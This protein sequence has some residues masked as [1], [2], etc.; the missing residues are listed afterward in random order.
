MTESSSKVSNKKFSFIE[1]IRQSG[2]RSRSGLES[3]SG[4]KSQS[5][6]KTRS[7]HHRSHNQ[8]HCSKP[9]LIEPVPKLASPPKGHKKLSSQKDSEQKQLRRPKSLRV[10]PEFPDTSPFSTPER[11]TRPRLLN[12]SVT[13]GRRRIFDFGKTAPVKTNSTPMQVRSSSTRSDIEIMDVLIKGSNSN[14]GADTKKKLNSLTKYNV[15]KVL[16]KGSFA[17]VK[18]AVHT[19]TGQKIALKIIKKKK[20]NKGALS[21]A[22]METMALSLLDHPNIIKH[23]GTRETEDRVYIGLEYKP[24]GDLFDYIVKRGGIPPPECRR[25]YKQIVQAI[26]HCHKRGIAHCD[27]KPENVLLDEKGQAYVTD[28]GLSALVKPKG[29]I[30]SGGSARY[31]SPEVLRG[32]RMDPR[33]GDCWSLGV[34]LYIMLSGRYPFDGDNTIEVMR[35]VLDVRFR[36]P[37]KMSSHARNL[38]NDLLNPCPGCRLTAQQILTSTFLTRI[39]Y[40]LNADNDMVLDKTKVLTLSSLG[41]GDPY[42]LEKNI[43]EGLHLMNTMDD[44]VISKMT[45]SGGDLA[46]KAN[47]FNFKKQAAYIYLTLCQ[48]E[49]DKKLEG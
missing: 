40:R 30:C 21:S 19:E 45:S 7:D 1:T 8:G 18:L 9:R 34:C 4:S 23:V 3:R 49:G 17:T 39:S 24:A 43:K 28:F 13:K 32:N 38:I 12:S 44:K 37:R 29:I 20:Q 46:R 14:V 26:N 16:G 10:P 36:F 47:L 27:V 35:K 22:K 31:A 5:R 41:W 2:S 15:G 42:D 48:Q 6:S 25:I 33:K 11:Q